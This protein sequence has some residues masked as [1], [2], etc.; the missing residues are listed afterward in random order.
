MF[1]GLRYTGSVNSE[2]DDDGPAATY[3][4]ETIYRVLKADPVW[5]H[6]ISVTYNFDDWDMRVIA[7]VSNAFD[8]EPPQVSVYGSPFS[9][10]GRS[11]F[12]SQ[13]DFLGQRWF[14]NLTKSWE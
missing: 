8:Q 14:L 9:T 5:Y 6:D 12:Y 3:R 1:W 11:P 4:G 7:G 13:Y 10:A 2:A